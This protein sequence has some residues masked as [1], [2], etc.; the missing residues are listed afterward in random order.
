[1][2]M[3]LKR[4]NK[5]KLTHLIAISPYNAPAGSEQASQSLSERFIRVAL[6]RGAVAPMWEVE[7]AAIQTQYG[8]P[9]AGLTEEERAGRNGLLAPSP[10]PSPV[11]PVRAALLP[12]SAGTLLAG[13]GGGSQTFRPVA[14]D[15]NGDGVQTTGANKTVAFDVDDSGYLKNT[16]WL[17][18]NDGFLFLDRN[19]N[20]SIDSGRELFSNSIVDL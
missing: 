19:L 20:G 5:A 11:S 3:V 1:M 2:N 4:K 15:L 14:L 7:T 9:Q 16:A 10:Q 17:N 6:A 8:D 13:A 18:N 12:L